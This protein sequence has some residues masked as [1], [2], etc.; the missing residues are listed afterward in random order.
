MMNTINIKHFNKADIITIIQQ[1]FMCIASE[2]A[3]F[4]IF[5]KVDPFE[6]ELAIF[7]WNKADLW[8]WW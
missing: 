2:N 5:G 1:R 4:L 6:V 3:C 8:T 7:V